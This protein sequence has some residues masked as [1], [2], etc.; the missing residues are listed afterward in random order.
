MAALIARKRRLIRVFVFFAL[1]LWT[2]TAQ[3]QDV[4]L[5]IQSGDFQPVTLAAPPWSS[6]E[7]MTA[8]AVR[9][10]LIEDLKAGPFFRVLDDVPVDSIPTAGSILCDV[11]AT[12][13]SGR[14]T[15]E[16]RLSELLTRRLIF[17]ENFES[18]LPSARWIAHQLADAVTER[19]IGEPGSACTRIAFVSKRNRAKDIWVMDWDGQGLRRVTFNDSLNLSPAWSPDGGRLAFASF[20]PGRPGLFV[21][22]FRTG[23]TVHLLSGGSISAPAWSPDGKRI[24][25]TFVSEGNADIAAVDDEGA[26]F[27]KLTT[28]PTIDCAPAWSPDGGQIAFTSD[29]SGSPQVY[30]MDAT[31]GNI[32]R[33]TLE[34]NYNDSAAWSPKGDRIAYVTRESPGFQIVVSD[35]LGELPVRITDRG[36]NEDP[37]WSPDGMWIAFSSNRDGDWE[38]FRIHPDGSGL[39]R[40]GSVNGCT[41][42][43]WSPRIKD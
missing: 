2:L 37:S 43:A 38:L 15:A 23:R 21:Y 8:E 12:V 33:L 28:Q 10:V 17:N 9:R 4:Y 25:F 13:N 36:S 32:R 3:A 35:V 20:V 34:G 27:E 29:R 24:A 11:R 5:K 19:L 40:I 22:D 42:P 31:G 14:M 39:Q 26:H 18:E 1:V 7:P 30:V 16:A 6:N 41:S